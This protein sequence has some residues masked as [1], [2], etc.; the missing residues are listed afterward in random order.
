LILT[1][2]KEFHTKS[3]KGFHSTVIG[4]VMPEKSSVQA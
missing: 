2:I 3:K 1:K 4:Q